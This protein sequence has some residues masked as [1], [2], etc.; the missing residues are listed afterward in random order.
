M[1]VTELRFYI[2]KL[3]LLA[4]VGLMGPLV[5]CVRPDDFKRVGR[6]SAD[7]AILGEGPFAYHRVDAFGRRHGHVRVRQEHPMEMGEGAFYVHARCMSRS[8]LMRGAISSI[9]RST[10]VRGAASTRSIARMEVC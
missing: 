6:S 8:T 7:T 2:F 9:S 1:R 4:S 5:P 3:S 10:I